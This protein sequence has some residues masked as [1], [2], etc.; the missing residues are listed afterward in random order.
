M[1]CAVRE[2]E[3][4]SA[5]IGEIYDATLD[6]SLWIGVLPECAKFV[7]GSAAALFCRDTA[8]KSCSAAYYSGIGPRYKRL[9]ID[10]CI[11]ADPLMMAHVFARIGEPV[12]ISDIFPNDELR[13]AAAYQEWGRPQGLV[14]LLSVALDKSATS[15]A[16]LMV[17][18][19]ERDGQV[20]DE[21]RR[22]M[23]L[24]IPHVRRAVLI[25]LVIH[26]QTAAAATFSDTLDGISAGML[27]VDA[28]GRIVHANTSGQ[29]L[30]GQ[31]SVLRAAGGKLAA[32]DASAEQALREVFSAASRGDAAVGTKGIDVP[33]IAREG[34]RYIAHVLPLTSGARRRAGTSY[35]AVAALFVHEAA[36][37]A[38]SPPEAIAK[39][40]KL[41]PSELRV[42]L[43]IVQVG[44]VPETA[45]ALGIGK[46]TVRTHLLR[47]YAKTG[48]CHQVELVK[49][50][51]GF[52]NPLLG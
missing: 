49:L 17:F 33:L 31:G 34:T 51:A 23:R 29:A 45:A 48:T 47:L 32:N 26:L 40:Y 10:K 43:G 50:V 2:S 15:A 14:D 44:S 6:P 25:G 7:G 12:A 8:R 27:L 39:T 42:L 13:Q 21:M 36:L 22:R 37:Q 9:I 46:A 16:L 30:L 41:T 11:R 3:Q 35:A 4:L 28:S 38:P 19:H 24:I 52:A 5:V 20:D 1:G 18:R